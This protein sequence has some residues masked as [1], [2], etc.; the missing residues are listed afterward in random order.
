MESRQLFQG[1]LEDVHFPDL[2]LE[3]SQRKESGVL[4]ISRGTIEKDIYFQEGHI[5][6]AKSNDPDER[7][8]ELLLRRGRI[9][10]DQLQDSARKIVPGMRLGTILVQEGY[11]KPNDLY[12]GVIDQVEEILYTLFE[13]ADGDYNFRP[14]EL[15]SKEVITLSISTADIIR[16]GI[17]RIWRWSWIKKGTIS[18]NT[19][20]VKGEVPLFA[21]KMMITPSMQRL[22]ELTSAPITLREILAKSGGN[23][24]ET[25]KM[26]WALLTIGILEQVPETPEL[27]AAETE[28]ELPAPEIAS[29]I[30]TEPAETS[31]APTVLMRAPSPTD[32]IEPPVEMQEPVH[33]PVPEPRIEPPATSPAPTVILDPG[34]LHIPGVTL[35]TMDAAA[36]NVELSFSDFADL[37]EDQNE[38][39]PKRAAAPDQSWEKNIARDV[40]D[41]NE[42]HRYLFEMLRIEM[43]AG[44]TNFLGKILKKAATKHPMI[45][46]GVS[47]NE[48]GELNP[49]NLTAN[50]ESNGVENYK[51][52]LDALFRD[53]NVTIE[54]LLDK[55]RLELISTGLARIEE[56]QKSRK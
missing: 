37:A 39:V 21:K 8:G 40:D 43:G 41:F 34:Q 55:K 36:Q 56:S 25:C 18:L 16:T 51:L 15:P 4:H 17:G 29:D 44:V 32:L 54:N 28:L 31:A 24:F 35:P 53:E 3:I 6:F 49:S 46:E 27:P 12:Q 11:I 52:A 7:L 10:Y 19:V 2:L 48:F 33:P 9:T 1:R 50:I 45:F 26:I 38:S 23:N 13:W 20:F 5:V 30:F 42:R 14:G 22:M 47:M